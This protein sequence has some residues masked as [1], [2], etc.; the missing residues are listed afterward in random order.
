MVV[1]F[2]GRSSGGPSAA[3]SALHTKE[4]HV[5]THKK[6]ADPDTAAST[7]MKANP[8]TSSYVLADPLPPTPPTHIQSNYSIYYVANVG[9]IEG[10][11][12]S[13][14]VHPNGLAVVGVAPGHA[15]LAEATHPGPQPTNA[16]CGADSSAG[17]SGLGAPSG[18]EAAAGEGPAASGDP[19][20]DGPTAAAASAGLRIHFENVGSAQAPGK[21]AKGR[22]PPLRP[23]AVLCRCAQPPCAARGL[24]PHSARTGS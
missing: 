11:D 22:P 18:R 19:L 7:A 5:S 3:T 10:N 9:G 17:T 13:I 20:L 8:C 2:S 14:Y 6:E 23:D 21:S 24:P 15:A 16:A 12:Q 1:N 4:K